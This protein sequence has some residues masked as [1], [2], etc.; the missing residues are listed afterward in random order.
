[1][2]P[3][4]KRLTAI[5]VLGAV[6]AVGCRHL[7]AQPT[8]LIVDAEHGQV[9]HARRLPIR[10]PGND[11]TFLF[12]P[13]F[14]A[15]ARSFQ[16]TWTFPAWDPSGFGGRPLIGNPQA[17]LFYPPIWLAYASGLPSALGWLTIAHLLMAGAGVYILARH[18]G[19]S[20]PAAVVAGGC[21]ELS[22][23]L[24]AQVF[25]GHYPH[26]WAAC[27]YPW[28]F[29]TTSLA[30]RR[31]ARGWLMLPIVLALTFLTGHP[32]EW[33]YLMLALGGWVGWSL[34]KSLKSLGI[35]GVSRE[36][37]LWIGVIGLSVAF[38]AVELLP[39]WQVGPWMLKSSQ[40]S[41]RVISRYQLHSINLMQLFHPFALGTPDAYFGHDNYWETL[42]SIGLTP[43]VLALVAVGASP[44]RDL[45]RGWGAL[46]VVAVVLAAGKRLGLYS[47][48][49][50]LLPGMNRFRVPSRTLFL[51]TLGASLL[52]GA[53]LD[54]FIRRPIN[55][56]HL[57]QTLRRLG[58]A[59][60]VAGLMI[61]SVSLAPILKP[62]LDKI[63]DMGA[64]EVE[65]RAGPGHLGYRGVRA[66]E[67]LVRNPLF[68][69]SLTGTF[70][71]LSLARWDAS[72]RYAAG[73]GLGTL[74]LIELGWLTQSLL[75]CSSVDAFVAPAAN[76]P[77]LQNRAGPY[78]V[79][80]M[81]SL[82]SDWQAARDGVEKTN[83]ND[84][85]QIHHAAQ[86]YERLYP[87]LDS[88]PWERGPEQPM[89]EPVRA[90]RAEIAQRVL[91]LLS[92]REVLTDR[93][94]ELAGLDYPPRAPDDPLRAIRADNPA[95]LP[96]AYV[97]PRVVV[98]RLTDFEVAAGL[99]DLDPKTGVLLD[100]DP[101][102]G[103]C[104][105]SFT[106]AEWIP[107]DDDTIHLRVETRAPGML[108]VG[109]TWMP[110]WTAEVDGIDQPV[111]RANHWQQAVTL[112]EPGRHE[113]VLRYHAPGLAMGAAVTLGSV[114][115]WLA[116]GLGIW[117]RRRSEATSTQASRTT[118]SWRL[119]SDM[120][121]PRSLHAEP[122]SCH[123]D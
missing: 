46:V 7:F 104:G 48:A 50:S 33:Y 13:R 85:F 102:A 106:P 77:H 76:R 37:L 70:A 71:A 51:A 67:E 86:L 53:G 68:W 82:Y 101:L 61:T 43:L 35:V 116:A 49:Y 88:L 15:L 55:D 100:H 20:Q 115:V 65:R 89:D 58:L 118:G 59:I 120:E 38:C 98:K 29:W 72:R 112:A 28:A 57:I 12:L 66:A 79:A 39:E 14:D 24:I 47:L 26:V 27:W 3:P 95:A 107:V 56:A 44:R 94:M 22:P 108:V 121:F 75:V 30:L 19:L 111:L 5:V 81:E 113:V 97:V 18:F 31:D 99:R 45:V 60:L 122:R 83:V 36:A 40:I 117:V 2:S 114:G 64:T 123:T 92:V 25:E 62:G 34:W 54:V 78:R 4:W 109:N 52:S 16:H 8:A 110:G 1:M 21:Y 11:L 119:N 6:L 91:D 105:Q 10:P 80:V 93:P 9:D 23:Y 69:G 41:L 73:W 63:G 87:M 90:Y 42:L 74:A 17:G 32:Q 84:W 96:R 103:R